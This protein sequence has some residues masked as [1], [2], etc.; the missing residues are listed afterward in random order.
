M[1]A[2]IHNVGRLHVFLMDWLTINH[3]AETR[4]DF[5]SHT[6]VDETTTTWYTFILDK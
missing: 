4:Q 2:T 6:W 3:R 5:H 1:T